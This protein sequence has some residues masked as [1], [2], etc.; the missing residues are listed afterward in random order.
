M[1]DPETTRAAT[2]QTLEKEAELLVVHQL[3]L[4]AQIEAQLRAVHHAMRRIER[5]RNAKLRVGVELSN[6]QRRTTLTEL[7]SDIAELDKQL[8]EEHD[9]CRLMQATIKKMQQRLSAL[10]HTAGQLENEGDPASPDE[11]G[12]LGRW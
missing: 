10:K 6:G 11:G 3:D 7:S 4:L 1:T 8:T 2:I 9:C 12:S 5:L